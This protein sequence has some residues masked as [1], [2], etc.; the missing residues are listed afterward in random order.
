MFRNQVAQ[1]SQ[2]VCL[3]FSGTI[4][5]HEK[6]SWNFRQVIR[7][8]FSNISIIFKMF[9]HYGGGGGVIN[10]QLLSGFRQLFYHYFIGKVENGNFHIKSVSQWAPLSN[11]VRAPKVVLFIFSRG[12]SIFLLNCP[13]DAQYNNSECRATKFFLWVSTNT[14]FFSFAV[15]L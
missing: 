6:N 4:Q 8:C 1:R 9:L 5:K 2:V 15:E 7:H 11:V 13:L 3:E 14:F 10:V 12:K